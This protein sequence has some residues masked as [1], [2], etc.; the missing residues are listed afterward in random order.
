[1]KQQTVQLSTYNENISNARVH[2]FGEAT[3]LFSTNYIYRMNEK[4]ANTVH[5]S[6]KPIYD[7]LTDED[8]EIWA[9]EGDN[10]G[11]KT[12]KNAEAIG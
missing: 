4:K 6:T 9:A 10:G 11:V 8:G 7:V 5:P 3:L 12:Y 1:V 2:I